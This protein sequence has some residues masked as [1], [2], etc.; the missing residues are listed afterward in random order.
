MPIKSVEEEADE[1]IGALARRFSPPSNKHALSKAILR[2][3]SRMTP[4]QAREWL[5]GGLRGEAAVAADA[6]QKK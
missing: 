1:G 4:A 6:E 5:E 3:A 2:R